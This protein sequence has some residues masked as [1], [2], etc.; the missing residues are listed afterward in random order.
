MLNEAILKFKGLAPL[1][2]PELI[3]NTFLE[4][5]SMFEDYAIL[6][7]SVQKPLPLEEV[8]DMFEDK[9]EL[10]ILYH[11]VP[12]EQ[13]DFGHTCCAYRKNDFVNLFREDEILRKSLP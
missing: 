10:I 7:Y 4:E 2:L 3:N 1:I 6:P 12:S 9:M 5:V 11:M 8:M 13:T